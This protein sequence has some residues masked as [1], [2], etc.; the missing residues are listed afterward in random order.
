MNEEKLTYKM[1]KES[2]VVNAFIEK[3]N[4]TLGVLGYTEHSK[5][6]A[7]KVAETSGKILQALGYDAH[8][9][10]LA[11]IA[12]YMHDIGNCVNRHD[13]P[14]SGAIMAFTLLNRWNVP[15]EDIAILVSAIGQ[16]DERTGTAVDPVS[17]ALILADKCDVRRN[18]VRNPIK[19]NFDKH[20]RVNY[21]AV[22][23]R[24]TINAAEKTAKLKIELDENICS[25]MDYF[26]IFMQ[27]MLMCKRA[28]E[29]LGL[30][31]KLIANG[32]KIC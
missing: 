3:G 26:E 4:A 31:F 8:L 14:H 15:S 12:G 9:V 6:H 30:N 2:E 13:H 17:A 5:K 16:H 7:T 27:R 18:R 1:V 23:S 10:E 25:I 24:L 32:N 19:A 22:S 28:S 20:D 21:A 11:K 29:L